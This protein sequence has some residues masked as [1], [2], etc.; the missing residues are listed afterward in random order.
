MPLNLATV[1]EALPGVYRFQAIRTSST[2]LTLR[3][4]PN[5]DGDSELV[6]HAVQDAVRRYLAAQGAAP[7]T[8]T[9]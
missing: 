6:W 7:A 4:E 2:A 3:I 8:L 1:I 5:A 9:G